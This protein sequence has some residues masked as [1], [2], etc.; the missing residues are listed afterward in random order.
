MAVI[1]S[2]SQFPRE[3]KL[4]RV[5]LSP[6]T[7]QPI[8]E[9]YELLSLS[10]HTAT[11]I[12]SEYRFPKLR[13]LFRPEMRAIKN[14]KTSFQN[15]KSLWTWWT[16]YFDDAIWING[17]ILCSLE[18]LIRSCHHYSRLKS[19]QTSLPGRKLTWSRHKPVKFSGIFCVDH[20]ISS[21]IEPYVCHINNCFL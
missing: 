15:F 3:Q 9:D 6:L 8:T 11:W 5:P 20:G 1:S 14:V 2:H 17:I 16:R 4:T 19:C 13:K 10:R 12:K 7:T 18:I 21:V